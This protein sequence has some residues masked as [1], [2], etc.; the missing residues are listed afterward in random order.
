L[1][2]PDVS[3]IELG[4]AGGGGLV[5]LEH[6]SEVVESLVNIHIHVYGFDTG[7]GHPKPVDYRDQP[8]MW[9]EGQLPMKKEVVSSLLKRASLRLGLVRDT[10]PTFI[11]EEPA[12]VAFVSFDLDLYRSTHD[13][14]TLFEAPYDCS[15]LRVIS[16]FDDIMGHTYNDFGGERLAIS[17]FNGA[18]E[19]RKLSPI[20]NLKDFVPGRFHNKRWWVE[21]FFAHFFEHPLY[22]EA[23]SIHK[24]VYADGHVAI[25][26]PIHSN[27]RSKID[28][29]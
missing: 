15:L 19:N 11:A 26:A 4:V 24:T 17:E 1:N 29:L 5:S 25:K 12:P 20:Y 21:F 10:I 13:A 3:V 8:N 2:I 14:F 7:T 9:F 28:G 16:Y 23:D 6:T 27:W 18:H 22:N